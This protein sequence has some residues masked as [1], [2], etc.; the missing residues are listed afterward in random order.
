MPRCV[1]CDKTYE[2]GREMTCSDECHE[3]LTRRLIAEFGE[4]KKVVRQSTGIAYKVPTMDI[5]ERSV[6]EEELDRYPLWE[7]ETEGSEG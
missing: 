3:E 7:E 5:I 2:Q 4:F 1:I 6:K